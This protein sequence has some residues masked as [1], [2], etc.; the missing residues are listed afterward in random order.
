MPI[1]Q[2]AFSFTAFRRPD[3][4][5][6]AACASRRAA[7]LLAFAPARLLLFSF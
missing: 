6:F 1:A 3:A 7:L 5:D 4:A 2:P